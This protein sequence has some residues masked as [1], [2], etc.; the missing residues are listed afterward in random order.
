MNEVE[1]LSTKLGC[2]DLINANRN[3]INSTVRQAI[4]YYLKKLDYKEKDRQHGEMAEM[5]DAN[6]L[7]Y[8]ISGSL[9][10]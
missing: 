10:A 6:L 4:S 8:R 3:Q 9:I 2:P 7:G 1:F 5:V